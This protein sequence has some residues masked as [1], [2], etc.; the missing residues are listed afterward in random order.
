MKL[1]PTTK[2]RGD[3]AERPQAPPIT[4]LAAGSAE[5]P[6]RGAAEA[7]RAPRAARAAE[8]RRVE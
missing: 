2:P 1:P 5:N 6:Y 7:W 8:K 4:G 3:R